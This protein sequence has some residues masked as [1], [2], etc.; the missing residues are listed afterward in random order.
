[1]EMWSGKPTDYSHLHAFGCPVYVM[2]NTQERAKL[3]PKSRICIFQGYVDKVEGYSLWDPTAYKIVISRDVIFVKDQ[4]QRRDVDD[5]T[6]KEKPETVLVYMKNNPK[7][8]NSS[9]VASEHE[10]QEPVDSDTLEV[11]QSTRKRRPPIWHLNYVIETDVACCLLT[12]DRK[13]STFH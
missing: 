10:E 13:P 9:E 2:Y 1:M 6:V 4:M 11:R 8:L 12:E 5:G 7:D 3:D